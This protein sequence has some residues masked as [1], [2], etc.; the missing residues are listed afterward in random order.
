VTKLDE[1][2]LHP[3]RLIP[4]TVNRPNFNFFIDDIEGCR[5]NPKDIIKNPEYPPN[6]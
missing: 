5:S 6:Q 4:E 1:P 3:K 2:G